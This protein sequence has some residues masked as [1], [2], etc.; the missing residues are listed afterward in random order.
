MQELTPPHGLGQVL[1]RRARLAPH[2]GGGEGARPLHRRDRHPRRLLLADGRGRRLPPHGDAHAGA[3]GRGGAL[4]R[5]RRHRGA[6]ARDGGWPGRPR[7]DERGRRRDGSRRDRLR[8]LEPE[9]RADGGCVHSAHARGAPDDRHRARAPLR[10]RRTEHRVPDRARHG[11]EHVRAT[12]RHL[13]R[14]RVVRAPPD[15]VRARG[16][17]VRRGGRALA[18]RVPV[19]PGGLRAAARAR[20][21]ADARDRRGRDR[22]HQVRDQ[23]DPLAHARR[24]AD[25]R[26]DARGEGALVG[27]GGL[28]EG[29]A[30][31]RQGARRVD[32]A[33]RVRDRPPHLRRRA[34]P[35]PPQDERPREGAGVGRLQ[36]DLRHRPP[37]RAVGFEP[38]RAAVAV[39]LAES[40][41]SAPC[42]SRR[43]AGSA[44]SGTS[45]TR[46]CSRSSANVSTLARPSGMR[47]GGRRSSTPSTWRCESEPGSST[48][49][50]SASST[51]SARARS[52]RSS[53]SRCARSTFRS[54]AW[55][56]RRG[57]HRAAASRPT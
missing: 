2:S 27:G 46:L 52:T 13:A 25:P 45:R 26:R 14:D 8:R 48:C 34:L 57:S 42:S 32:G 11:H 39:Q 50:R 38:R 17:A 44:R 43:P 6:G 9:A 19:H 41:S 4:T 20:A 47:A 53:A 23:R 28:G 51:S 35:R 29:R 5:G 36:Q 24:A 10:A 37:G 21:R 18:D 49:R 55:C 16:P 33:R 31:R 56:T 22:R 54:A 30:W 3:G 1:G 12:G 15:P 40:A 7:P